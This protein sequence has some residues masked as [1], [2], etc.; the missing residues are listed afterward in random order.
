MNGS[1]CLQWCHAVWHRFPNDQ[2]TARHVLE[3]LADKAEEDATNSHDFRVINEAR[4]NAKRMIRGTAMNEVYFYARNSFGAQDA[5][6][7]ESLGCHLM[8]P[9]ETVC[10]PY[11]FVAEMPNG[12]KVA[13][14]VS[15]TRNES[16]FSSASLD[17]CI[18]YA[19][20]LAKV[21]AET[22][23]RL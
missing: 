23:L 9:M 5:Q 17:E 16:A 13:V 1:I 3:W 8:R 15:S 18:G 11:V 14:A 12:Y 7:A 10:A 19:K 4:R 22:N 21:Y 6:R 20:H 2:R